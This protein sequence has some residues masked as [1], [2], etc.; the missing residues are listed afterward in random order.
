MEAGEFG[1][2]VLRAAPRVA[3]VLTQAWCSQWKAMKAYLDSPEFQSGLAGAAV[4]WV[5]YDREPFFDAF[6]EWKEETF[7]ND[8]VPYVR[9]YRDGAPSSS[10]NYVPA[11]FFR[12]KL[13]G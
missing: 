6:M 5:E 1:E 8:Q 3:I 7:R 4:F 13:L 10:G 12:K 2:D 11:D 9:Y